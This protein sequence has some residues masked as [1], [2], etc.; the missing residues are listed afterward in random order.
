MHCFL[1]VVYERSI[2]EIEA[3]K[4]LISYRSMNF[5]NNF[6]IV[7]WDNSVI[8]ES[9]KNTI[10]L[11]G[12]NSVDYV[13]QNKNTSL[14][15]LYN[16]VIDELFFLKKFSTV[17]LLDQDSL[18]D[19]CF[20]ESCLTFRC[21]L[22]GVPKVISNRSAKVVSP[23]Y[24]TH[25]NYKRRTVVSNI[26]NDANSMVPSKNL[27]ALGS[28]LTIP[29]KIWE[30]GLRFDEKLS[31][32]GVDEEF[33]SDYATKFN[34]VFLM[35]GVIIH[36]ISDESVSILGH[37]F[38][39]F[40]KYMQHWRYRLVKYNALPSFVSYIFYFYWILKFQLRKVLAICASKLRS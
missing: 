35:R 14:S 40:S 23:R 22:L 24:Q 39:R 15:I 12:F 9:E 37:H 6:S 26:L 10:N 34:T 3:V 16:K 36:D 17:T 19:N 8:K 18:L 21:N 33:C 32:Y 13:Y 11:L 29:R 30:D 5:Y 38:W 25:D 27:F 2:H 7:I 20:I 4:S 1:I 28:G 31:F